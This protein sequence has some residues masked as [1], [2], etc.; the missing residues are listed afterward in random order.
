[1][2]TA[3]AVLTHVAAVLSPDPWLS[4]LTAGWHRRLTGHYPD[5]GEHED[6]ILCQACTAQQLQEGTVA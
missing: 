2:R 6:H 1:M 5:P 3:L 4:Q